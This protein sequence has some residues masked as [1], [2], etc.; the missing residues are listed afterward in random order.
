MLP[1]PPRC[2]EGMGDYVSLGVLVRVVLGKELR[3]R[4]KRNRSGEKRV[5][6]L[7][8]IGGVGGATTVL[9]VILDI[10]CQTE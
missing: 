4:R 1:V 10:A 6:K 2:V 9:K 7:K 5:G 8:E 3:G